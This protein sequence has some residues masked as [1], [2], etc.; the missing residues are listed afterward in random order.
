MTSIFVPNPILD[1][2]SERCLFDVVGWDLGLICSPPPT[3][4]RVVIFCASGGGI[5]TDVS[6]SQVVFSDHTEVL[7]S[8][9]ARVVTF[10]DKDGKR[11][12]HSLRRVL[13]D[14][15]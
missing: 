14:Q 3:P 11:E 9:E 7:L 10:V 13:R 12:T 15:R 4:H 6:I 8:E 1:P 5:R 2:G